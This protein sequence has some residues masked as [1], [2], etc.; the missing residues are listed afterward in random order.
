MGKSLCVNARRQAFTLVELLIVI[1]LIGVLAAVVV[2]RFQSHS[3]RSKEA[4]L[5]H[6]L[7]L[8]RAALER[9]HADTGRWPR[10]LNALSRT[11][12]PAQT[13]DD[14]G[15]LV[16]VSG[17]NGPYIEV[18][19]NASGVGVIARDPVSG[20]ELAYQVGSPRGAR[21]KSS[22]AGRASDG[23]FYSTW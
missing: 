12:P 16:A 4:A 1:I 6:T 5:K 15:N 21:V 23:T 11:N 17:W 2:P 10:T 13:R 20:I 3:L 18:S 19:D 8:H 7:Q 9:F 22:A 14:D